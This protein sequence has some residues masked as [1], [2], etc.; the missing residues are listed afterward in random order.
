MDTLDLPAETLPG[1]PK[2]TMLGRETVLVE[3]HKGILEYGPGCVRLITG[4]GVLRIGGTEL[5][6]LQLG[7]ELVTVSGRADSVLFED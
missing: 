2:V 1:V 7:S 5:E 6:L 3:N 4:L